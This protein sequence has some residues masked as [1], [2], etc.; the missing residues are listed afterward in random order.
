MIRL[1][2]LKNARFMSKQLKPIPK[3]A[4]DAEEQAFWEK[5]D[6]TD[7]LDWTKAQR[8]AQLETHDKNY[9]TATA[10]TSAGFHQG[11]R[12]FS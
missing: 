2:D 5:H 9:F 10:T 4:N 1:I 11:R 3:F 6:S 7:Y 12:E 8:V